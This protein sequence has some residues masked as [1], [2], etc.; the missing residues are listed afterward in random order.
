MST[1]ADVLRQIIVDY[2]PEEEQDAANAALKALVRPTV[3]WAYTMP[4]EP[5]FRGEL[6]ESCRTASLARSGRLCELA[7]R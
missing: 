2:V 5:F 7:R 1:P 3:G 4:D 6:S